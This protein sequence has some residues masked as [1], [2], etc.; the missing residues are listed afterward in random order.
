MAV[1]GGSRPE[2]RSGL[3]LASDYRR[4]IGIVILGCICLGF[5]ISRAVASQGPTITPAELHRCSIVSSPVQGKVPNAYDHKVLSLKPSMYLG[6]GSHPSSTYHDLSGNNNNGT[7][8]PRARPPG[9]AR[10]PNGS[11]A[12]QFDGSGQYVQVRSVPALSVTHTDCLTIEAWIRPATLQF[13]HEEGSGYAYVLGKGEPG[14]QEYALR[15]YSFHN[16]EI[17]NRPNRISAYVFN[18]EGGE[19]SGSYF[20]DPV[21]V[22]RWFMVSFVVYDIASPSFPDGYVS[23]YKNDH[24]RGRVSLDQFHVVPRAGNAPLRIATRGLESF[25]QGAIGNVAV[26]DYALLTAQITGTYRSMFTPSRQR[27]AAQ[28]DVSAVRPC[29]SHREPF[30]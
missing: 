11:L 14:R 2:R 7:Y 22:G 18:P 13:R 5:V 30:D 20:Q 10:L 19:G 17:P 25:F 1:R 27:V 12:A 9:I 15:M 4:Y 8:F 28:H 3:R 26:Y 24:L 6:L 29:R 16:A 23:I 21:E